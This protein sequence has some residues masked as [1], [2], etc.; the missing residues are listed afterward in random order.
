MKEKTTFADLKE[1]E[2]KARR[3]FILDAAER[4]FSSRVFHKV[5]IRDIAK[6]AGI[7]PAL[8][9]RYF[10]DQQGLFLETFCRGIENLVANL[11]EKTCSNP[12]DPLTANA[13]AY[14]LYLA[15]HLHYVRMMGYFTLEGSPSKE[16]R[17]KMNEIHS[18]LVEAFKGIFAAMDTRENDDILAQSFIAALNGLLLTFSD[19]SPEKTAPRD[20]LTHMSKLIARMFASGNKYGGPGRF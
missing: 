16:L 2:R 1:Q 10:P 6:E 4:V 3:D 19:L 5:N 13:Q 7:S 14:V 17:K 11:K 12:E 18:L 9:Y 15:D 8:I 20:Q